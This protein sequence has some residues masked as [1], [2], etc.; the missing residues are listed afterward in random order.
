M[1]ART[2]RDELRPQRVWVLRKGT[3]EVAIDLRAAAR[4]GAEIVLTVDGSGPRHDCSAPTSTR[5]L[6][7]VTINGS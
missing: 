1:Q 3:H 4:V 2:T 5:E 6:D 7:Q